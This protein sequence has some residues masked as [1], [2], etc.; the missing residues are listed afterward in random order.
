MHD[1]VYLFKD[2]ETNRKRGAQVTIE[3]NP[4]GSELKRRIKGVTAHDTPPRGKH[5][6][7]AETEE[8]YWSNGAHQGFLGRS[9]KERGARSTEALETR[10]PSVLEE[11]PPVSKL[12]V[13][14]QPNG[15]MSNGC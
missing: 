14:D 3:A 1:E 9:S 11:E 10:M 5:E 2:E 7:Y 6:A 12:N 13:A 4:S 15:S 8:D